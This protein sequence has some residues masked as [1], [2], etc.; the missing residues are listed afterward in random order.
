MVTPL[1]GPLSVPLSVPPGLATR[2]LTPSDSTGV[3]ELIAAA[4]LV[5]IGE[6]AIEEADLVSDWKRPSF[7]ISTQS[8]GVLDGS[9]LVAYAEVYQGR[10][11]DLGVHPDHRGRGLGRALVGWLLAESRRQGGT[12][13]GMPVPSGSYRERLLGA[14]G[15]EP[16]WD[17]WVLRLPPEVE[18]AVPQLPDGYR[19]RAVEG[20]ADVEAAYHVVEDA[21][22][23][24]SDRPKSSYADWSVPILER[25]GYEPWQFRVATDPEGTIVGV[26]LVPVGEGFGYVEKLAVRADQRGRGLGVALL[27]E[28]FA[29]ARAHGAERFELSTDSRTGALG[30]YESVGMV[31]TSTWRHLARRV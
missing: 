17:S 25:P 21:F 6:V 13:V 23:E 18:L 22:L 24:W 30:L 14:H 5:D 3:F 28:A 1:S 19:I 7:V 11:A 12:L 27:S 31:V 26:A 20:P 9:T 16:L 10:W 8:I 29:T 2:P 15:F 4:E